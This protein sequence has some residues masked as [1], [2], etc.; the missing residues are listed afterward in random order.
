[1]PKLQAN[2]NTAIFI[3]FDEDETSGQGLTTPP[4]NNVP[5][6]VVSPVT[7]QVSDGTQFTHYSLLRTIEDVFGVPCLGNACKA[8]SMVGHFGL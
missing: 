4:A 1:V 8:T 6:I 2:P 3:T 5:M 7:S